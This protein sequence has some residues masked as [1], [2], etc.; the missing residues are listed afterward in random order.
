MTISD[1]AVLKPYIGKKL[2]SYQLTTNI[3]TGGTVK[4]WTLNEKGT[5]TPVSSGANI[6]E[7]TMIYGKVTTTKVS[8]YDYELKSIG[9]LP[10]RSALSHQPRQQW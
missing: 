7:G 8:G 3:A 2:N 10:R 4:L 9:G 5:E 1:N 6:L